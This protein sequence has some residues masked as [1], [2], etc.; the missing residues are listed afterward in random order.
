M[1][2]YLKNVIEKSEYKPLATFRLT[3]DEFEELR[4]D[5]YT[6]SDKI[7]E[8]LKRFLKNDYDLDKKLED[9]APM[10]IKPEKKGRRL[11]K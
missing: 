1:F 8:D 10:V 5:P 9:E 2:F 7:A 11:K 6:E 4:I 3:G